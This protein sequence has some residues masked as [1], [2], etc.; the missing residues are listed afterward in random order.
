MTPAA[1]FWLLALLLVAGTLGLLLPSLWRARDASAPGS[2]AAA[3]ATAGST[4][5]LLREQLA[6]TEHDRAAGRIDA[7]SADRLRAEISRRLLEEHADAPT[8]WR[9]DPARRMAWALALGV[10]ALAVALYS[11]LGNPQALSQPERAAAGAQPT[12][13]QVEAMVSQMTQALEAR[14]QRGETRPEDG[15]AWA[16]AARTLATMQRFKE[17]DQAF[18]R[19][20]ALTPND[21]DLL[22]DRADILSLL[23]GQNPEGEPMRLIERALRIDPDQPKALALAGSVAFKRGDMAT[24]IRHW[25]RALKQLPPESEFARGLAQSLQE[26]RQA[27]AG[28]PDTSAATSATSTSPRL[29]ATTS[30]LAAATGGS[31][32]G[33][34]T[35]SPAMRALARP[36]DTVFIV[37]RAEQGP[38]MPLA[39]V[40]LRVADLPAD[41]TLDDS[42]AMSPQLRLSA[43]PDVV[44]SARISR[45]GQA[46]PESGDLIG[47]PVQTRVGM[48]GVALQIDRVQP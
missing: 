40:R 39:I 37:A 46:L 9:A 27:Q 33:R 10:P 42:S 41:F 35:L 31:I 23:Q 15:P 14:A 36:D 19:A 8:A 30:G 47:A 28:R 45:S 11:V 38:R 44:V 32:R 18:A 3:A 20:L 12:M 17:A 7:A 26:A 6:A 24:A 13:T 34:V 21:A 48:R 29:P 5:A 22:A 16:M 4:R 2:L 1:T 25:Q 43:Y